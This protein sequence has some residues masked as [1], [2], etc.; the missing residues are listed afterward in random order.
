[1]NLDTNSKK[2]LPIGQV[3][4]TACANEVLTSEDIIAALDRHQVGDWGE[5]VCKA[6]WKAND[7]ALKY[8][9]RILSVYTSIGGERFW[10]ITEADRSY[11]TVLLP[12]DY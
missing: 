2:Y 5:E 4:I 11:T 1:M 3:V 10:I 12:S 6:D 8:G 9:E 7:N